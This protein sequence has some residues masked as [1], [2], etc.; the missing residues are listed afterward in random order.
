LIL[1]ASDQPKI[2]SLDVEDNPARFQNA[3]L[4]Y[5]ALTSSGVRHS[6]RVT[7]SNQASYCDRAALIP[8]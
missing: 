4:G 8:L 6:E 5:E 3:G 2:V 7:M 1:N